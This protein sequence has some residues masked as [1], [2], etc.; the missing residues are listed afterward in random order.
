MWPDFHNFQN[1]RAKL[2]NF[3]LSIPLRRYEK[4]WEPLKIDMPH[5]FFVEI[6]QLV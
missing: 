6:D 2:A 1:R 4:Q 3:N 5:K